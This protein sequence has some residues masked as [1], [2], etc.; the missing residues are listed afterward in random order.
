LRV[1]S[2]CTSEPTPEGE[3]PT[4]GEE[5]PEGEGPTEGEEPP[6]G[7]ILLAS[8]GARAWPIHLKAKLA[9]CESREV[10]LVIQIAPTAPPGTYPALLLDPLGVRADATIQV[11]ELRVTRIHP[12][13]VSYGVS[14]DQVLSLALHAKNTGNVPTY[15]RRSAIVRLRPG[16]ENWHRH[17]H[18]AVARSGD[19]GHH[20][21]LDEFVAT[22]SRHEPSPIKGKIVEGA[23]Q[24]LP[25]ESRNLKL[26][27]PMPSKLPAGCTFN[28]VTRIGDG[29]LNL[30][31]YGLK[32]QDP[33]TDPQPE[34]VVQ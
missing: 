21:V 11:H 30:V 18:G 14:A 23:G 8:S 31:L 7:P 17:F 3:D 6:I 16:E 15:I 1:S 4:E 13:L 29:V 24:L 27:I 5:P 22:M 28:A 20:K 33:E 2:C 19:Q 34:E 10:R 25:G 32:A 26:E 12:S 9:A